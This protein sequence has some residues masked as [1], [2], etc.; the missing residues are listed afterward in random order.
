MKNL[1]KNLGLILIVLGSI[2]LIVCAF[3]GDTNN[4]TILFGSLILIL[5]GL[6]AHIVLNKK[7][8]D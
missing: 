3:I 1:L 7:I 4:N 5:V 8:T 2:I 6:I